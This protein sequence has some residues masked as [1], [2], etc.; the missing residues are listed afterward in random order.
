MNSREDKS[1]FSKS[2]YN[3]LQQVSSQPEGNNSDERCISCPSWNTC[4]FLYER[5]DYDKM[6]YD[7]HVNKKQ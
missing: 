3:T 6:M 7:M 2:K 5:T 1:K 4:R